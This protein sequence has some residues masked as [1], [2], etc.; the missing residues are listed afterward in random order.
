MNK[1]SLVLTKLHIRFVRKGVFERLETISVTDNHR[2]EVAKYSNEKDGFL[3]QA[4]FWGTIV[5][6]SKAYI[7]E[8]VL[9]YVVTHE[10]GHCKQ[11]YSLLGYPIVIVAWMIA[12]FTISFGLVGLAFFWLFGMTFMTAAYI[13]FWGMVFLSIGSGYSWFIEYKADKYAIDILGLPQYTKAREEMKHL[14]K[15]PRSTRVLGRLTHPSPELMVRIF[16]RFNKETPV[17][18]P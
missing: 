8:T 2:I 3:G 5:L 14:P 7:S 18:L 17:A 1:I 10:Y 11:W 9:R 12:F 13:L 15:L 16:R 6:N 4:T